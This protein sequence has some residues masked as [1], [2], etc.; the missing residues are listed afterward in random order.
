MSIYF[1]PGRGAAAQVVGFID[2]CHGKLDIAAYSL[3]HDDISQAIIRAHKRGVVLRVLV[4]NTQASSRYADD[5]LLEAEGIEL[6][7]DTKAGSMHNKFCIEHGYAVITG[8][9]NWTVNADKRNAENFV[10]LRLKYAV[11][12]F[13]A[14]FDRLWEINAP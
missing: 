10:L 14:E 11:A 5:E 8:S 13:Q 7:R 12:E 3:T 1:S 4:D 2:R 9:F 6:R